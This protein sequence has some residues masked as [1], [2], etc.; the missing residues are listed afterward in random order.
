MNARILLIFRLLI[1]ILGVI[2]IY[3]DFSFYYFTIESNIFVMGWLI[4]AIASYNHPVFYHKICGVWHGAITLYITITF[5][6]FA[7]ILELSQGLDYSNFVLHYV[8]PIAFI[9][10]W[11]ITD[12]PTIKYKWKFMAY[13]LIY[14]V[15]YIIGIVIYGSFTNDYPYFFL[16]IQALGV[17]MFL[18][19]IGALIGFGIFI[20]GIFIGINRYFF[21]KIHKSL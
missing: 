9:I 21:Q 12:I 3:L 7:T 20:G 2:G 15:V 19:W 16:D 18:A 13:W 8:V 14:P 17:P 10:D 5:I 1:L 4:L 6:I 11:A